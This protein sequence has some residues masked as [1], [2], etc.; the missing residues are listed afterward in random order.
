MKSNVQLHRGFSIVELLT[1][2]LIIGITAAIAIPMGLNYVRH[3]QALAAAQGITSQMQNA[4]IQAV[5]RNS[6][7]GMLL[8]LDYPAINQLQFTS[9]DA[10]PATGAFDQYYPGTGGPV[11]FDPMNPNYGVAPTPPFN[12]NGL[13]DGSASPHG[14]I[15]PLPPG[16]QFIGGGQFS[17]LLFRNNGSV[18]GCNAGGVG[19]QWFRLNGVDFEAQIRH[20]DNGLTR[21]IRITRNGRVTILNQ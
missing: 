11:V 17:S 14:M 13:P 8:N 4:R 15:I 1:V 9:L 19:S 3:Y 6:R 12:E 5:K 7:N 16:F 18:E 21:T 2:M 20:V 10:N